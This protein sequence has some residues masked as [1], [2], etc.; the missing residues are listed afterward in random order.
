[1]IHRLRTL[2]LN[3]LVA[4]CKHL[5]AVK[6]E[7]CALEASASANSSSSQAELCL[8]DTELEPFPAGV[9]VES[10]SVQ[11]SNPLPT[12]QL[13]QKLE[14][15]AACLRHNDPNF[16][17][18]EDVFLLTEN[19]DKIMGHVKQSCS[20][21]LPQR[22]PNIP[23]NMKGWTETKA[24]MMPPKKTRSK[25]AGDPAYGAGEKSGKKAKVK[26]SSSQ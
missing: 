23:P 22:V 8:N 11:I 25:R 7:F 20:S 4:F 26:I 16:L 9:Q 5:A 21:L 15:I 12:L 13:A 14:H 24:V 19:I 6:R 2:T 1:M 10:D 17:A 3:P 18:P